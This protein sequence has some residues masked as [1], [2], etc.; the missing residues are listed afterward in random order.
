MIWDIDFGTDS[1]EE[2]LA[3]V[4]DSKYFDVISIKERLFFALKAINTTEE[5]KEEL[6]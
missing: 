1:E 5:D 6:S 3:G 4:I 2:S